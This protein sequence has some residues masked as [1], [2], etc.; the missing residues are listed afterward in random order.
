MCGQRLRKSLALSL[1][2]VLLSPQLLHSITIDDA[3][4]QQIKSQ[5]ALLSSDVE[6][7]KQLNETQKLEHEQQVSALMTQIGAL[8]EDLAISKEESKNS[9]SLLAKQKVETTKWQI[10]TAAAVML[11]FLGVIYG[12]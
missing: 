7:L 8:Q 10:A 2:L 12:K 11:F 1:V 9:K 5:I 3:L 4:W 6:N